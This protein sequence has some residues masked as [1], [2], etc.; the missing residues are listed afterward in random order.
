MRAI[1]GAILIHAGCTLTAGGPGGDLAFVPILFGAAL[2]LADLISGLSKPD[3][4]TKV[5]KS[6]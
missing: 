4:A 6:D 3:A 5:P 1:A 2:V